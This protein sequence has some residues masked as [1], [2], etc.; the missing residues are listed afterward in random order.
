MR[1]HAAI[2]ISIRDKW[3][4]MGWDGLEW[5]VKKWDGIELKGTTEWYGRDGREW[6]THSEC[7]MPLRSTVPPLALA[8]LGCPVTHS[9]GSGVSVAPLLPVVVEDQARLR[10]INVPLRSPFFLFVFFLLL[11]FY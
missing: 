10:M 9:P 8:S 3:D 5:D 2:S 11:L 1:C 6:D 4:R 7:S